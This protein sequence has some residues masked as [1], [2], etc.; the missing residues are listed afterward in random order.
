MGNNVEKMAKLKVTYMIEVADVPAYKVL[1][2]KPVEF[3]L[4][5]Q[6]VLM[7]NHA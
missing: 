1:Q 2:V 5:V 4:S 7:V 6:Q 3:L